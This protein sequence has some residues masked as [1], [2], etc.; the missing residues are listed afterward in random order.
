MNEMDRRNFMALSVAT[1]T[2]N[3]FAS[4]PLHGKASTC[5]SGVRPWYLP[6]K[7]SSAPNN[8]SLHVRDTDSA[9]GR[10]NLP[11][12]T[13]TLT[14]EDLVKFHGHLCDGIVFSYLQ[15]SVALHKLFPDGVIDR[16][17]L[18]GAC[19]NSPC[20]VDALSYM[21]G[22]RINFKTLKIDSSLGLAH[23]I[24]KIS[25]GQT[26]KVQLAASSF[27]EQLSGAEKKI[28]AKIAN[29]EDVHPQEIDEAERLAEEFIDQML[30]TPLER[31]IVVEE[32][33]EYR[34]EANTNV[35]AFGNRGDVFNKNVPREIKVL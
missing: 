14:L 19:K 5:V 33:K 9:L 10:Y 13:K 23:V 12:H 22:A 27:H 32:L 8:I 30:H 11:N 2:L 17:D 7:L 25:T 18:V 35:E 1:I 20:M 4:E 24:Q 26:Y 3:S 28:R 31:L 34:F 6:Q 29:H 16:T 15:I 21:T